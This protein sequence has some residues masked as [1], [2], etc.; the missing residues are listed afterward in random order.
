MIAQTLSKCRC[1]LF[2]NKTWLFK[3]GNLFIQRIIYPC[4]PTDLVS[5]IIDTYWYGKFWERKS[6]LWKAGKI[7]FPPKKL[8]ASFCITDRPMDKKMY[9]IDTHEWK[10]AAPK[11]GGGECLVSSHDISAILFRALVF[12]I[13]IWIRECR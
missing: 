12:L 13:L 9:R 11:K 4:R 8:N 2:I 6:N 5:H 7:M 3:E 1:T 10:I